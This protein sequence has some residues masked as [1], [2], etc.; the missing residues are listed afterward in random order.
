V[1]CVYDAVGTSTQAISKNRND[2]LRPNEFSPLEQDYHH[3]VGTGGVDTTVYTPTTR[4]L[5][6]AGTTSHLSAN[7]TLPS[8]PSTENLASRTLPNLYA[9][10]RLTR[11]M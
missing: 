5:T 10:F 4:T 7:R 1:I 3:Q 6:I 11:T 8:K 2:L 9:G